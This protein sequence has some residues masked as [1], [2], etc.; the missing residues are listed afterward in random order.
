M[1]LIDA[2]LLAAL[3]YFMGMH[4]SAPR[5]EPMGVSVPR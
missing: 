5:G 4:S 3:A 1:R 2:L